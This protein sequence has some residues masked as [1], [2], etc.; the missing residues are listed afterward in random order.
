MKFFHKKVSKQKEE[1]IKIDTTL[2]FDM[3]LM[4]KTKEGFYLFPKSL[5]SEVTM[6]I[7]SLNSFI[8]EANKIYKVDGLLFN[9]NKLL[10]KKQHDFVG[11]KY[12]PLTKTGKNSKY[13]QFV[14]TKFWHSTNFM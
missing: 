9:S 2:R 10:F 7:L 13:P 5:E 6:D 11:L 14:L 3:N 1:T 12:E 4:E 8:K